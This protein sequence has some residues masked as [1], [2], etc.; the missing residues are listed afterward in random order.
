MKPRVQN[1]KGRKGMRLFFEGKVYG[2]DMA[3]DTAQRGL[4]ALTKLQGST[5]AGTAIPY[6]IMVSE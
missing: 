2:R 6:V 3:S 1:A 5:P 4:Q